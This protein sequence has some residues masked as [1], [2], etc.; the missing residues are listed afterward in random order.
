MGTGIFVL[1]Y[2]YYMMSDFRLTTEVVDLHAIQCNPWRGI[3]SCYWC[4]GGK[5]PGFLTTGILHFLNLNWLDFVYFCQFSNTPNIR[6]TSHS[7]SLSNKCH[8]SSID[9]CRELLLFGYA[10][11]DSISSSVQFLGKKNLLV[12]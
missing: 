3:G 10:A 7:C 6:E 5:T 8:N 4:W 2:E 9:G 11:F 1:G 12:L